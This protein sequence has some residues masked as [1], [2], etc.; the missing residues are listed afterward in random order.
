MLNGRRRSPWFQPK[1]CV[2]VVVSVFAATFT[3]AQSPSAPIAAPQAEEGFVA[4]TGA[5][6]K[7]HW[8]GYSYDYWPDGWK[9]EDGVLHRVAAAG[10]LMTVRPYRD[11]EL[12]FDW[13]VAEGGN[14]GV[15]Y[16][17]NPQGA[18]AWHTGLEYQV[19]DNAGH[20]DGRD[21]IHSAGS[22]YALY[23]ATKAVV[24]PAGEW[25]SG[26]IRVRGKRVQHFLNGQQA[27][28][29]ELGSDDWKGRVAD[30]KFSAW[31]G[32]G[33][34]REGRI[35]L[36]DHGD[37]VWFRNVRIKELSKQPSSPAP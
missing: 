22:I 9:L 14:S 32:F 23:P 10:D 6:A 2:G 15:I 25:N 8:V 18:K 24:K 5:D 27:A 26:A 31:P 19:L 21:A 16:L 33:K 36:Q 3:F 35:I 1:A 30:S 11:F 34:E 12:R 13:R 7:N 4:L 17:V 29:C 20:R 28:E 37:E